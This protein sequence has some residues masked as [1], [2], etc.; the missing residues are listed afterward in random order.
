MSAWPCSNSLPWLEKGSSPLGLMTLTSVFFSTAFSRSAHSIA[1]P[2]CSNSPSSWA[3]SSGR[4]WNGAV[5]SKTSF[6]MDRALLARLAPAVD[7]ARKIIRFPAAGMPLSSS[8]PATATC[9]GDRRAEQRR[10]RRGDADCMA[11][12]R[13]IAL[14]AETDGPE[15]SPIFHFNTEEAR[16]AGDLQHPDHG[17]VLRVAARLQAAVR[18]PQADA[19]LPPGGGGP[20]QRGGLPRAPAG[21]GPQ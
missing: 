9:A 4:P 14:A 12:A 21:Q 13:R 6:F 11:C 7:D 3:T 5:V 2:S 19:G 20:D 8:S 16:H 15:L 10:V 17:R 18:R 1:R